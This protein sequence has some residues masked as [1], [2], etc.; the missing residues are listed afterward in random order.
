MSDGLLEA[1]TPPNLYQLFADTQGV[2]P[3]WK[4]YSLRVIGEVGNGK[5]GD[6]ILIEGAVCTAVYSRGKRAGETNWT[7]RD[8]TTKRELF[9]TF[10]QLDVVRDQWER[11]TGKCFTCGGRS[12]ECVGHSAI[13]GKSMRGC[14]RCQ[15]TGKAPESVVDNERR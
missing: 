7:K 12:L 2:P 14:K 5:R 9:A 4:W 1:V 11:D 15:A 13:E 8:R 3:G 6:G 10:A